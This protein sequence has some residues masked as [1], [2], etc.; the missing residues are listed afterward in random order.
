MKN[1]R[2]KSLIGIGA[3]VIL[4]GTTIVFSEPG[5]DNDPLVTMSYVNNKVEQLKEYI[6]TKIANNSG[7]D[8]PSSE[9]EVVELPKGK[10]LIGKAGTEIILRGG[11][12]TA[13]GVKVDQGLSDVTEGKDIDNTEKLLPANHLIIIPRNDG[14]GA[15]AVSD[16]IFLVRGDYHI[17]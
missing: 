17:R 12:A 9:L 4:L 7:K 5:S 16:A 3:A 11:K 15:Y 8:N 6:D 14:R 1:K 10:Y 13:H 2:R